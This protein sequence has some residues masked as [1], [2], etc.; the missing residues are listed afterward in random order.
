M[1]QSGGERA[2]ITDLILPRHA[3]EM[4]LA[5]DGDAPGREA[6]KKLA[7]RATSAGWRVRIMKCPDGRDWNDM[8]MEE[9]AS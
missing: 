2:G 6:A 4:V 5:P 8:L 7:N 3:G 9:V 1:G